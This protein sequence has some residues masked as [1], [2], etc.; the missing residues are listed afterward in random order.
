LNFD[1][2]KLGEWRRGW[3]VLARN[4]N[5]DILFAQGEGFKGPEMEEVL[6]CLFALQ[7][8]KK[9]VTKYCG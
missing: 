6:T 7:L 8:L 2:A 4:S 9:H 1:R 3:S 5:S